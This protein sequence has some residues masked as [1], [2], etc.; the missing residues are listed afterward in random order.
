MIASHETYELNFPVT[1][2]GKDYT[3]LQMRRPTT[4]DIL[5]NAKLTGAP[6]EIDVRQLVDLCEVPKDVIESLDISD[7]IGAQTILRS[8]ARPSEGEMRKAIMIL[9]V[10]VGWDLETLEARPVDDII[11]W[12]K[13]LDEITPRKRR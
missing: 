13:T 2:Q 4:R 8:F 1:H 9:S 11:E 10:S 5:R 3:E 7:L 6:L 12:L